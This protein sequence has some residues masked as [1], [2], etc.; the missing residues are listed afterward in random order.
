LW[1]RKGDARGR[2][3]WSLEHDDYETVGGAVLPAKTEVRSPGA[4]KR[5]IAIIRYERRDP[6]PPW[7]QAGAEEGGDEGGEE[8]GGKDEGGWESDDEGGW[9]GDDE[10]GWEGEAEPP[11]KTQPPAEVVAAPAT[12]TAAAAQKSSIPAL[13]RLDPAGLPARGDLCR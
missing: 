8:E 1:E 3:L 6:N 2:W 4:R 12:G 10:G 13:F 11:A 5:S 7:A 9:E